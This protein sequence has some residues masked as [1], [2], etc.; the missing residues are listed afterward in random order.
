[1]GYEESIL[2]LRN[3]Y[4]HLKKYNAWFQAAATV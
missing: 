4:I 2:L 3:Q 1:M